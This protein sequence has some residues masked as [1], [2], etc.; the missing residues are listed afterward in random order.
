MAAGRYAL[1]LHQSS[2]FLQLELVEGSWLQILELL[3]TVRLVVSAL[4]CTPRHHR[5]QELQRNL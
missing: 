1:T 3:A 4:R 5:T 2:R